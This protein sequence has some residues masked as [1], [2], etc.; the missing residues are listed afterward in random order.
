MNYLYMN[1]RSKVF[2]FENKY[3]TRP[4]Y[5]NPNFLRIFKVSEDF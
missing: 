2:P 1:R 3:N 4:R 5:K